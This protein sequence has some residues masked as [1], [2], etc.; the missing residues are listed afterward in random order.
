MTDAVDGF[1]HIAAVMFS[2]RFPQLS[3]SSDRKIIFLM[4]VQ[5]M[6]PVFV[7]SSLLGSSVSSTCF[8]SDLNGSMLYLYFGITYRNSRK[9]L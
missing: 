6:I 5:N 3:Q 2:H 1:Q 4:H 7:P 8:L 9:S